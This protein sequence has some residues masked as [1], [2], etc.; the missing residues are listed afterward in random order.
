MTSEGEIKMISTDDW[1]CSKTEETD[2]IGCFHESGQSVI[3]SNRDKSAPKNINVETRQD[4]IRIDNQTGDVDMETKL[5][6]RGEL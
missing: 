6:Y 5:N 3:L 4:N 1:E 2:T